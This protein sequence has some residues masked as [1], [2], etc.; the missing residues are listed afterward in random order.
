MPK[1]DSCHV[2]G[3]DLNGEC[4]EV[5]KVGHRSIA[6]RWYEKTSAKVQTNTRLLL[7]CDECQC[8]YVMTF[9]RNPIGEAYLYQ[10]Q[11]DQLPEA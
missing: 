4:K 5:L 3:V 1:T 9:S 8:S 6:I 2:D 11:E 7:K 10:S